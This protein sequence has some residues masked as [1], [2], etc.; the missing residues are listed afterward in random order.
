MNSKS[1]L[2][3]TIQ[4]T[5]KVL[6]L[7]KDLPLPNQALILTACLKACLERISY[8][9]EEEKKKFHCLLSELIY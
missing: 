1:D 8:N 2:N 3:P 6:E 4:Y 9:P 7:L 5:D